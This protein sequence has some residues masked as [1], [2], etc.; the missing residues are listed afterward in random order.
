MLPAPTMHC[1]LPFCIE[2]RSVELLGSVVLEQHGSEHEFDY[3]AE[4]RKFLCERR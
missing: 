4:K 1:T 2:L 3:D